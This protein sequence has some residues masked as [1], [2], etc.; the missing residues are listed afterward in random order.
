MIRCHVTPLTFTCPKPILNA[1]S[2]LITFGDHIKQKRLE[3][4]ILQKEVAEII[5]VDEAT[6]HNWEVG[7]I[8]R[9]PTKCALPVTKFLGYCPV[10]TFTHEGQRLSTFCRYAGISQKKLSSMI[11]SDESYIYNWEKGIRQIPFEKSD[12]LFEIFGVRFATAPPVYTERLPKSLESIGDHLRKKRLERS[13]S[14]KEVLQYFS[15]TSPSNYNNW[16]VKKSIQIPVQHYPEIVSFL[17]YCP[18]ETFVTEGEKLALYRKY[19][20]LTQRELAEKIGCRDATITKWEKGQN[21]IP[22]LQTTN[23]QE[24][25][26]NAF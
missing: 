4:E 17:N 3:K 12:A 20:G 1:P 5:G 13:L 18:I 11:G 24:V 6:I 23:I 22:K 26:G 15:I 19:A 10:E 25:F 2:Q 21:R 7:K 16:E 8:A 9:V 14:V